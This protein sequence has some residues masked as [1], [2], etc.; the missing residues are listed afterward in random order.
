MQFV[1]KRGLN[2][3]AQTITRSFEEI[4]GPSTLPII[5][6]LHHYIPGIGKLS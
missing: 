1:S 2:T 6:G 3:A 5:G 4:P